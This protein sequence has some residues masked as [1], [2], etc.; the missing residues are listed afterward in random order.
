MLHVVFNLHCF[1]NITMSRVFDLYENQMLYIIFSGWLIRLR[2]AAIIYISVEES[3][4]DS[5][6]RGWMMVYSCIQLQHRFL[7]FPCRLC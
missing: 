5:N 1:L 2:L 7:F 6:T 3:N 4:K